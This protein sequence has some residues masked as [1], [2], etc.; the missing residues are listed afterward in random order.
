VV[1]NVTRSGTPAATENALA[2]RPAYGRTSAGFPNTTPV[3]LNLGTS[4]AGQ[5][6]RLRFRVGSDTNT[7]GPGWD[8]D[9][10]AFTGIVGTPFPPLVADPGHCNAAAP[11]AAGDGT[12]NSAGDPGADPDD[13]R[14]VDGAGCRAGG[15][16]S[17]TA[18]ALGLLVVLRHRRR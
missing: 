13:D 10:V 5:T 18:A 3:T 16:G 17:G 2:G 4:L 6:F 14:Q 12:G 7:G 15:S 11:P 1:Y 8:I 9:N